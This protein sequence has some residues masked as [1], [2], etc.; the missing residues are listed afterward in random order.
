MTHFIYF[1]ATSVAL[2][3]NIEAME[4]EVHN[5]VNGMTSA[6]RCSIKRT[7]VF[8]PGHIGAII[9]VSAKIAGRVVSNFVY[10]IIG[11]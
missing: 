3:D 11:S 1:D 2:E 4:K 9:E 8:Q 7:G 10:Y 5:V 6:Y